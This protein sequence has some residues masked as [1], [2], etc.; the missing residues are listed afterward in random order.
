MSEMW[1]INLRIMLND[2]TTTLQEVLTSARQIGTIGVP[3]TSAGYGTTKTRKIGI[4]LREV[5]G[6]KAIVISASRGIAIHFRRSNLMRIKRIEELSI[7]STRNRS[8][9]ADPT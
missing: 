9:V 4:T 2:I 1:L 8:Q 7:K 3:T 6:N 5:C